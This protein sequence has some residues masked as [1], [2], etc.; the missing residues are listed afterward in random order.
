MDCARVCL[1]VAIPVVDPQLKLLPLHFCH[2]PGARFDWSK[3]SNKSLSSSEP[4]LEDRLNLI[5]VYMDVV[6]LPLC[7]DGP[8]G[9]HTRLTSRQSSSGSTGSEDGG[10]GS[11]TGT[12]KDKKKDGSKQSTVAKQFGSLGK[13]VGKKLKNLGNNLA[14]SKAG[15]K[16]GGGGGS[17]DPAEK[18]QHSSLSGGLSQS[19]KVITALATLG[20]GE[21]D[22][23]VPCAKLSCEYLDSR[24]VFVSNYLRDAE[25][26]FHR[27][28][29]ERRLKGVEVRP[30]A[31]PLPPTVVSQCRLC[32]TPGCMNYALVDLSL[33]DR[34]AS[35]QQWQQGGTLDRAASKGQGQGQQLG[36]NT[37]PGR[38][39]AP[40]G[41]PPG[42]SGPAGGL[43]SD[44][45]YKYGKSKFYTPH[46]E[47]PPV[48][49]AVQALQALRHTDRQQSLST[50]NVTR[51]QPPTPRPRSPSPD[52]DNLRYGSEA[53]PKCVTPGCDF[54]G[55]KETGFLCSGC[56]RNKPQQPLLAKPEK[57]TRL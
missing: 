56:H 17:A 48:P 5:K 35:Q 19:A 1:P 39:K 43:P 3:L 24:E 13:S 6:Q 10:G 40:V 26:R 47:T 7:L 55:S 31:P 20:G 12:L 57:T 45:I 27:D 51:P 8:L 54:Y 53:S 9:S 15:S 14:P 37:F 46:P 30:W 34:C 38:H 41:L 18:G 29:E 22:E 32:R 52:Y 49:Q 44:E 11:N 2:D 36:Y 23:L 21:N 25:K 33:C 42:V 50:G 4:C 16:G 28:Q